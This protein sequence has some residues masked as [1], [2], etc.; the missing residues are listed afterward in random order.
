MKIRP[1]SLLAKEY[2][3]KCLSFCDPV[4][5]NDKSIRDSFYLFEN[6]IRKFIEDR[7]KS[8]FKEDWLRQGVPQRIRGEW[9]KRR[10]EG[11]DEEK[12][13][14]LLHFADFHDYRIIMEDNKVL[15]A[16]YLNIK[17][18]NKR[19]GEL[20]P[21]R[22]ALAHSRKIPATSEK[23]VKDYYTEFMGIARLVK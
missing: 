10:E 2:L 20:E 23:K 3:G 6:E 14:S 11:L 15:F 21:I 4:T 17:T 22:N 12:D 8:E 7:L 16:S 13:L 5:V 19:L 9:A 1:D 18:W